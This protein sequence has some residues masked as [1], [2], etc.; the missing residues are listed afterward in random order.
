MTYLVRCLAV[1]LVLAGGALLSTTWTD[2]AQA[3]TTVAARPRAEISRVARE[4]ARLSSRVSSNDGSSTTP[5]CMTRTGNPSVTVDRVSKL[6]IGLRAAGEFQKIGI[7]AA[8][9]KG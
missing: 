3:Q 9:F 1:V 7:T 4:K 2:G 5:E 8:H 6:T